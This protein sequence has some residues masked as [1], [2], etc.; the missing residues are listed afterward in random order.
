MCAAV[1]FDRGREGEG[2]EPMRAAVRLDEG[3]R[4]KGEGAYACHSLA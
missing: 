2:R 3:R 4:G 1:R